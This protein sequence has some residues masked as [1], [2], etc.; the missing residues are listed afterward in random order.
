MYN[1]HSNYIV[2]AEEIKAYLLQS[3]QSK[4]VNENK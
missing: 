2:I 4:V 1:V 3:A